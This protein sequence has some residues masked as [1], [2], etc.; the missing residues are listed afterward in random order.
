MAL[1]KK[2]KK[3]VQLVLKHLDKVEECLATAAKTVELYISKGKR[4]RQG[5]WSVT[6]E[7]WNQRRTLSGTI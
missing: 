7:I 3:V 2:E 1:F 4:R 6:C 5:F